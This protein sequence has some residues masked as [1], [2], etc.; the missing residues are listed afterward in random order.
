[1]AF[2][3]EQNK[4]LYSLHIL[5][6]GTKAIVFGTNMVADFIQQFWR[7]T[8]MLHKRLI[9]I[10]EHDKFTENRLLFRIIHRWSKIIMHLKRCLLSVR[11]RKKGRTKSSLVMQ[12]V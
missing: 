1:M 7:C 12:R 11:L 10:N 4:T 6:F 5:G 2:A 8:C 3:V 9:Q